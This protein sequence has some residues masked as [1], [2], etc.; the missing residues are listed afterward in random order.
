MYS[1]SKT[2]VLLPPIQAVAIASMRKQDIEPLVIV[3]KFKNQFGC[4]YV[5]HVWF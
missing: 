1:Q 4:T 5:I 2:A 3:I